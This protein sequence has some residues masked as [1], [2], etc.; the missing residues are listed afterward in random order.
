MLKLTAW[1]RDDRFCQEDNPF[2]SQLKYKG[3]IKMGKK[4]NEG[5]TLWDDEDFDTLV[6][7]IPADDVFF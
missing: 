3:G 5:I 2:Y 6:Y 1:S 7:G 4:D